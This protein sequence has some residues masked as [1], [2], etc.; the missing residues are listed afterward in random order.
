MIILKTNY[1]KTLEKVSN[2]TEKQFPKEWDF[3]FW[4]LYF[5]T[6]FALSLLFL[7]DLFNKSIVPLYI[8]I[9]CLLIAFANFFL[10]K[11][12]INSY[13]KLKKIKSALLN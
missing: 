6:P 2:I 10:I 8:S 1:C 12:V 9:P 7:L 13:C 5:L 11:E 3:L 4:L